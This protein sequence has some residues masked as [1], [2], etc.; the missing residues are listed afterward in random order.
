MHILWEPETLVDGT[1]GELLAIWISGNLKVKI[2][3]SI[4]YTYFFSRFGV[5]F[6]IIRNSKVKI[7]IYFY[8][9]FMLLCSQLSDQNERCLLLYGHINQI[10]AATFRNYWRKRITL[11]FCTSY[12]LRISVRFLPN[13]DI[14]LSFRLSLVIFTNET[15]PCSVPAVL[16]LVLILP[17]RGTYTEPSNC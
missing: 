4:W 14:H 7:N 6:K 11:L 10:P 1:F 2:P 16:I 17:I 13:K 9:C 5:V 15:D 8:V 3:S 12:S